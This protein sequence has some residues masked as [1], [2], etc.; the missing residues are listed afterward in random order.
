[1]RHVILDANAHSGDAQTL[2]YL[3]LLIGRPA[4]ALAVS[5]NEH[6]LA[7]PSL[8]LCEVY[9]LKKNY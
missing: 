4:I 2:A 5:D 7:L 6:Q 1:M 9:I 8:L 3:D